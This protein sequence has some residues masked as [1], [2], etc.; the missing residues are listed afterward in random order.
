MQVHGL[1]QGSADVTEATRVGPIVN[2][3]RCDYDWSTPGSVK[4]PVK[5][6]NVYAAEGSSWEITA[7]PSNGGSRVEMTWT[8]EFRRT[9]RGLLFG[10]LYRTI[11]RPI[12]GRYARDVLAKIAATEEGGYA[13][14]ANESM[15]RR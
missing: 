6:S 2:W 1:N 8:R 3:E 14:G 4:A 9:P 5:D 10:T 11:G 15:I 12:F 13:P 7:A